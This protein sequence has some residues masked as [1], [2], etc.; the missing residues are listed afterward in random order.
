MC[1]YANLHNQLQIM[2]ANLHNQLQMKLELCLEK[3]S[4]LSKVKRGDSFQV[5]V[6]VGEWQVK[7]SR[8]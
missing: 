6:K 2:Y 3:Q 8:R 1:M 4:K 5:S 7:E